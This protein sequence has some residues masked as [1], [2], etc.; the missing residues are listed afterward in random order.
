MSEFV[1]VSLAHA[2]GSVSIMLFAT[3]SKTF[4]R[5]PTAEAIEHD[6]NKGHGFRHNPVVSWRIV[7][8]SAFPEDR[9]YRAA[10]LDDGKAIGHDMAKARAIHRDVLRAA[11]APRLAELDVEVMKA[12]ESKDDASLSEAVLE[13]QAL[14]DAP[15]DPRIEAAQTI[16]ELRAVALPSTRS[17]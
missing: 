8:F 12:L 14:R 17:R 10:W 5:E 4:D 13:K 1:H 9:A 6:I 11:R 7:P 3:K 16:E 15:A 2:D